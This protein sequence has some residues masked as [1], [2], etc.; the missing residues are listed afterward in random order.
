LEQIKG[1]ITKSLGGFYYLKCEDGSEL[2][3]RARGAFRNKNIKPCVGDWALAE[4]T[5]EGTGYVQEILPR[6]NS[7]V[8]PPLANLDQLVLVVSIADPAPNALVL[9]KLIAIAEYQ[10]IQP[11]IVV[12][13]ADLKEADDFADIYRKAGFPVAVVC[14]INDE[15]AGLILKSCGDS[16]SSIIIVN[17]TLKALGLIARAY[18]EKFD[19][20]VAAVTGSVGKT[21]TKEMVAA[22]VSQKY[23]TLK[24]KANFNNEIGL[25]KTLLQLGE[26]HGAAVVEMGMRGLGE[27]EYLANIAC[28]SFGVITNIGVAHMELLGSRENILRAKLELGGAPSVKTIILNGDDELLR[29]RAHVEE[30]LSEYGNSPEI[31]YFGTGVNCD[32]RAT[33]IK[34]DDFGYSFRLNLPNGE[35]AE[36][37][38]LIPG[39]HNVYNALAAASCG[40]L[41]GLTTESI[42]SGIAGVNTENSVR[43]KIKTLENGLTV[44]DD[45]YNAGPESMKAS[46]EVL[47]SI[48]EKK[49]SRA[50]TILGD[51]LELGSMTEQAHKDVGAAAAEARVSLLITVGQISQKFIAD[52]YMSKK[53]DGEIVTAETSEKAAEIMC[54]KLSKGDTILVKGSHAMNMS[55]V[56]KALEKAVFDENEGRY[57]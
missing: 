38:V 31:I 6:S 8:R 42:V 15:K 47:R 20:P 53:T 56:T 34:E 7:L 37:K 13:K 46:I 33:D 45:T 35:I 44:I 16:V 27:I 10:K 29:D 48:A 57:R 26:E 4:L 39:I 40:Y 9:D 11:V 19:I 52:G 55:L 5:G 32:V 22:V 54:E 24:T 25:P 12:T 28:P 2:E 23:N 30:I 21:S 43:Q 17:D 50:V 3:C 36:A 49:G 14:S 1:R 41:C 51:M 18:R